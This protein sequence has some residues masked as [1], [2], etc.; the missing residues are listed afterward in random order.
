MLQNAG[1]IVGERVGTVRNRYRGWKARPRKPQ[2]H[3]FPGFIGPREGQEAGAGGEGAAVVDPERAGCGA[4]RGAARF[5]CRGCF[6]AI[7]TA[8]MASGSVPKRPVHKDIGILMEFWWNSG[9]PAARGSILL[10]M[11][12]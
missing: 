8:L 9:A 3:I 11:Q 10:K 12:C 7:A 2:V 1:A 4:G 6:R 5:Q